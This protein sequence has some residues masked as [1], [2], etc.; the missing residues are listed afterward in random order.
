MKRFKKL[1][2]FGLI[3]IA[4]FIFLFKKISIA[5]LTTAFRAVDLRFSFIAFSLYIAANIFRAW[6]FDLILG[7]QV[8]FKKFLNIVFLQNFFSMLLPFRIGELSYVHM[9]RKNGINIG[10]NIASLL[11]ARIFDLLGI[12]TIF[13]IALLFSYQ[14][15]PNSAGLFLFAGSLMVLGIAFLIIFIFYSQKVVNFSEKILPR[16]FIEKLKETAEGF[17]NFR[18]EKKLV[19]VAAQS[20]IIWILIFLSGFFLIKGTGIELGFWRSLFVYSLPS[21]VG[22]VPVF[23]LGGLG[24]YE[25]SIIFGLALF[26]VNKEIA[27]AASL[28][29]HVQELL[30]V[31]VLAGASVVI[32]KYAKRKL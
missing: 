17:L 19:K 29:L 12:I 18:K 22:F 2:F 5:D 26:G 20:F 15:I 6:R 10:R 9:V 28:V 8:G 30:F 23:I 7:K 11:G 31:I 3:S 27:I 32:I 14:G 16:Y 1:I 21:L 24:F 25:G 4:I 13:T